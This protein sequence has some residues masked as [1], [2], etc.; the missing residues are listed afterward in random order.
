MFLSFELGTS[1]S[2]PALPP[3][4]PAGDPPPPPPSPPLPQ[5]PVAEAK[6]IASVPLTRAKLSTYFLHQDDAATHAALG[7]DSSRWA[8]CSDWLRLSGAPLPCRTGG[9]PIECVDGTRRCGTGAENTNA[10]VLEVDFHDFLQP[11][12]GRSYFFD[13]VFI[14]PADEEH[15]SLLFH[16]PSTYGGDVQ[17]NRGWRLTLFDEWR[18]AL[19]VQCQDWN[20]GASATEHVEGLVRVAHACLPA[21]APTA[22]YEALTHARYVRIDLIGN[23]RQFWLESIEVNFRA[24]VV[25]DTEDTA[26][27]ASAPSP[28]SPHTL[29]SPSPPHPS[30]PPSSPPLPAF[31]WYTQQAP[32]AWEQRV[33]AS[34][35]CGL[36]RDVCAQ[37]ASEAGATG[38]VMSGS[39]CCYPIHGVL[40]PASFVAFGA[41]GAGVG[42]F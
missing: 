29:P 20:L 42:V 28:P 7:S 34:E 8:T 25:G 18:H 30:D 15:G 2:P 41:T 5:I 37:H 13:L 31:V 14:L 9:N 3:V 17:A 21:T 11:F 16:P 36:E 39:G 26:A 32:V 40:N 38:F 1:F 19:P 22:S 12:G 6:W 35:P 23:F 10:P 33:V 4:F 27:V 24:T